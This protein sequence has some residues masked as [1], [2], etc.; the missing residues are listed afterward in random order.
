MPVL[1]KRTKYIIA[2]LDGR[3]ESPAV[4]EVL[5]YDNLTRMLRVVCVSAAPNVVTS[6]GLMDTD[7]IRAQFYSL[8]SA[9]AWLK[10]N[11][12]PVAQ[13]ELPLE[14]PPLADADAQLLA[15]VPIMRF[16][17]YEH[18]PAHLRGISKPFAELALHMVAILPSNAERSAGLRKLLEAKDACVRAA[19]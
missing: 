14:H 2:N 10:A 7:E 4:F 1:D 11:R 6:P 18:L 9:M 12:T 19:L 5:D 8:P 3:P 17:H 16:F 15:E 13:P